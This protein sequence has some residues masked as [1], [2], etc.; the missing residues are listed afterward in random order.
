MKK[1]VLYL[2]LTISFVGISQTLE[3]SYN[4]E[5]INN[6]HK[7][8]AFLGENGLYYITLYTSNRYLTIWN[9]NHTVY[10]NVNLNV[11]TNFEL[12]L[13]YFAT[14]KLFNSDSKIE[15]LIGS[16]NQNQTSITRK[17]LLFNED[18]NVIFDFGH[19]FKANV[20]KGK[21]NNFKLMT[22]ISG[23]NGANPTVSYDIY[24]LGGTLSVSQEF[25]LNK[26][27]IVS[28]P[29]PASQKIN[30]TNPFKNNKKEKIEV[31]DI[32]GRKVLEKGFIG[33]GQNI[34]LD[35]SKLSN[36]VYNYKIREYGNKFVK[37]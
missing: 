10:K 36:G 23:S 30:I 33:N 3:K 1:I 8:Y 20:F 11:P 14:D 26:Q 25:F 12:D 37:E 24:S 2:L 16:K 21:N 9:E 18:G 27:K 32:N 34:E 35:I 22:S 13:L 5:G 19:K 31:Y 6:N 28:F 17:M 4:T 29:N 7:N 15:I